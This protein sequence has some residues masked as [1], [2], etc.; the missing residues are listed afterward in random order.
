MPVKKINNEFEPN[1]YIYKCDRCHKK[2][3]EQ[4]AEQIGDKIYCE[5]CL[6]K[7]EKEQ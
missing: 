5:K 1:E 7:I 6:N 3:D 4:E 2:I